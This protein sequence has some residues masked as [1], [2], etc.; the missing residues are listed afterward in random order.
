MANWGGKRVG[1]G[2][3]PTHRRLALLPL[4]YYVYVIGE[5]GCDGVNKIG[6]TDN[7]FKRLAQAQ[8][9]N[10]RRLEL[11][12]CFAVAGSDARE[13]LEKAVHRALRPYHVLGEWFEA[14]LPKAVA[15]I[16]QMAELI[17]LELKPAV[18]SAAPAQ[19][20]SIFDAA[21]VKAG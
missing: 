17:G 6:V 3:K 18:P 19:V 11:R 8:T 2:R 10:Y 4:G 20:V 13:L 5:S 7:P 14:P 1:S 21:R 16:Q 12:A 9:Y 15:T